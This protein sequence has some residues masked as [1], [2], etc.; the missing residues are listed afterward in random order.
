MI[1]RAGQSNARSGLTIAEVLV[2]IGVVLAAVQAWR[3][4]LW[5]RWGRIHYGLLAL[6]AVAGHGSPHSTQS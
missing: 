1:R 6:A 5:G 2:T 3:G 4:G